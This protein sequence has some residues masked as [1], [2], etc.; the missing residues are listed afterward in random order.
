MTEIVSGTNAFT[1]TETGTD[2]LTTNET[3]D[4]VTGN[5]SIVSNGTDLYTLGESGT[6][7]GAFSDTV[8]GTDVYASTETGNHDQQ[9]Y[10]QTTTGGGAWVRTASGGTLTSGSGTN[11]YTL[12]ESGDQAA[13]HFSQSE[14]GTDRYGLVENFDNVANTTSG[15]TPGNVTF[16]SHGLAFQDPD[17]L[18]TTEEDSAALLF[19]VSGYYRQLYGDKPGE[20][21]PAA[22]RK[23]MVNFFNS[24]R[25]TRIEDVPANGTPM[26]RGQPVNPYNLFVTKASD[27]GN[28]AITL[29]SGVNNTSQARVFVL[30]KNQN[31][32]VT[33]DAKTNKLT[34]NTVNDMALLLHEFVH[35][36]QI[37]KYGGNEFLTRYGADSALLLTKKATIK[38]SYEYNVF[39]I[40]GHAMQTA[41]QN[42]FGGAANQANRDAL[43]ALNQIA[44]T[45]NDTPSAAYNKTKGNDAQMLVAKVIKEFEKERDRLLAERKNKFGV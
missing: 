14:T 45:A 34:A 3:D 8:T 33:T 5:Y 4:T 41:I 39:E 36:A 10:T 23:D 42:V 22:I 12:V 1:M 7:S 35:A 28:G 43:N 9:T 37:Y 40:D 16:H 17:R 29:P 25:L 26:D 32:L 6:L 11:G 20:G 15:S 27:N 2:S 24:L 44:S 30:T 21:D 31:P 13:G 38:E 18:T 19:V